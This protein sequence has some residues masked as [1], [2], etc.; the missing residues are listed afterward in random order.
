VIPS[1]TT[2]LARFPK[3]LRAGGAEQ[4]RTNR[5][6]IRDACV[7]MTVGA[8]IAACI[9]RHGRVPGWPEYIELQQE[10]E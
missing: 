10:T 7:L 1:K 6:K 9:R 3:G 8:K 2:V 5:K 4:E